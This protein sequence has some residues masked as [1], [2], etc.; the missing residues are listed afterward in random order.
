MGRDDDAAREAL[1][2]PSPTRADKPGKLPLWWHHTDMIAWL[3]R[4]SVHAPA[5]DGLGLA[6]A[7][8]CASVSVARN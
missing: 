5:K 4:S 6:A 1:W 2:R 8:R 3:T 7:F